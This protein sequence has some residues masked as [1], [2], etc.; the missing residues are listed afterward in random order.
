MKKTKGEEKHTAMASRSP[1]ARKKKKKK[2]NR[3]KR[4]T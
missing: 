2:K 1:V 4:R 3:K